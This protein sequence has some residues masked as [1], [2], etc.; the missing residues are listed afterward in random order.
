MHCFEA[1]EERNL[2]QIVRMVDSDIKLTIG[3][4]FKPFKNLNA[5]DLLT[6]NYLYKA[7]HGTNLKSQPKLGMISYEASAE[8]KCLYNICQK[9][10]DTNDSKYIDYSNG[11]DV[12]I[13]LYRAGLA[14]YSVNIQNIYDE[15][16]AH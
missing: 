14:K 2:H 11:R 13:L 7:H 1:S 10:F 8:L 12:L 16:T 3:D 6:V 4:D 5:F 15:L 9:E